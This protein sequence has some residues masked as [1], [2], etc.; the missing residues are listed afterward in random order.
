MKLIYETVDKAY[1]NLIK[2]PQRMREKRAKGAA[3]KEKKE[4]SK[5]VDE[6]RKRHDERKKIT[7]AKKSI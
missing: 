6:I 7:E 4:R 1:D 2:L 3:E 5:R